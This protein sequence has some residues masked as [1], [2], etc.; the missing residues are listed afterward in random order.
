VKCEGGSATK[1]ETDT[2]FHAE[3]ERRDDRATVTLDGGLDIAS[4]PR[5]SQI[6]EALRR[7]G[8]PPLRLDLRQLAYLDN[9]GLGALLRTWR[10]WSGQGR[11]IEIVAPTEPRVRRMFEARAA[12]DELVFV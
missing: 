7:E 12:D 6:V 5:F 4:E 2:A 11:P 3:V 9:S 10:A 8:H 1:R